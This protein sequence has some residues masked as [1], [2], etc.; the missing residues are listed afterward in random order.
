MIEYVNTYASDSTS[1]EKLHDV[2]CGIY[3]NVIITI[4]REVYNATIWH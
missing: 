2:V 1:I 4:D 3:E